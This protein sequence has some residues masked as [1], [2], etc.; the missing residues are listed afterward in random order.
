MEAR[1][2]N[3]LLI[4]DIVII[5]LTPSPPPVFMDPYEA[6]FLTKKVDSFISS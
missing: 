6:L 5:A 1:Q 3:N 4:L 2:G